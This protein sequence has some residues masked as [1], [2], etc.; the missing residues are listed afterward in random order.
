[1]TNQVPTP[2][3]VARGIFDA[4]NRHDIDAA[5]ALVSDDAVCDFVAIGQFEG[6]AAIRRYFQELFTA[7]PNFS[8]TVDRVVGDDACVVVQW[9]SAG[10]FTGGPFQGV[11]PTGKH[12]ETRGVD[13]V[14][15]TDGLLVRSTI[16]FDGATFARQIGMLPQAGSGAERAMQSAFN[17][18]TRLRGRL[19]GS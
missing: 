2:A 11:Q 17:A 16:Y 3:S 19:R 13:V 6:K 10:D 14:E 18:V 1:M 7:M 15:I 5:T 12:V 9:H 8:V 4:L